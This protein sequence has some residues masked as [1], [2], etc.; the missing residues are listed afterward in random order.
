MKILDI[1]LMPKLQKIGQQ[2]VSASFN[3]SLKLDSNMYKAKSKI[4]AEKTIFAAFNILKDSGGELR[5][6]YVIDKIRKTVEFNEHEKHK[7][8]ITLVGRESKKTNQ[9][10][11]IFLFISKNFFLSFNS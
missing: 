10:K 3:N 11:Q 1:K 8:E 7:Y 2:K 4:T 5:G 9:V 6:K